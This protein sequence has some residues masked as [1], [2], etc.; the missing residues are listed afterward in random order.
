MKVQVSTRKVESEHIVQLFD[1]P[2]SCAEGVSSFIADALAAGRPTLVVAKTRNWTRIANEL[3]MRGV[4]LSHSLESGAL[5][6]LDA[7]DTL[8]S[9]MQAERPNETLFNQHVGT[10]VGR[11]ADAASAP[12]CVYGEMVEIL[13][14]M[15]DF[16]GAAELEGLWNDLARKH[17]FTLLCGYSSGHFGPEHAGPALQAICQAHSKVLTQASDPLGEWL[18]SRVKPSA[19]SAS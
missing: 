2:E 11:L 14:E 6:V 7:S 5:T 8:S 18:A 3:T 10:L 9:F 13:A 4:A 15:G 16:H 1:C 17:S 12:L 19:A